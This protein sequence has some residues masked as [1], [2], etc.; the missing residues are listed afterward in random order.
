MSEAIRVMRVFGWEEL[1]GKKQISKSVY[2]NV[3]KVGE[4]YAY[5]KFKSDHLDRSMMRE[6]K[7]LSELV[8]ENI[9]KLEG[10][11]L[12]ES[13]R[14]RGVILPLYP[15]DLHDW[16][17]NNVHYKNVQAQ[18]TS[19]LKNM[20]I[21][22]IRGVEYIHSSGVMHCDIKEKNIMI[23]SSASNDLMLGNNLRLVIID[24]GLA[25]EVASSVAFTPNYKP[26][27]V[28]LGE[29]YNNSADIWSLGCVTMAMLIGEAPFFPNTKKTDSQIKL[30]DSV[31]LLDLNE[32]VIDIGLP[33]KK[34]FDYN[35]ST[36]ITAKQLLF[37]FLRNTSFSTTIT[38]TKENEKE[39]ETKNENE[40]KKGKEKT[41]IT[42]EN[43]LLRNK[44]CDCVMHVVGQQKLRG[45]NLYEISIYCFYIVD[46]FLSDVSDLQIRHIET[47]ID[48]IAAATVSLCLKFLYDIESNPHLEEIEDII[49]CELQF[50]MPTFVSLNEQS[51]KLICYLLFDKT[52]WNY[53][54]YDSQIL[55]LSELPEKEY[56]KLYS[57]STANLEDL[58]TETYTPFFF[59][60]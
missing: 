18:F 2:G 24:F 20:I 42:M 44:I 23:D 43:I 29:T 8:H 10:V 40:N 33:I 38:N 1:V 55:K 6:V 58:I 22:L 13:G 36:R 50:C 56:Q 57:T 41:K 30:I 49:F 52:S 19:N 37:H 16:I 39:K 45:Y 15:I 47:Q 46:L 31:C 21:Q 4:G 27:E 3:Y 9:I 26:I 17:N 7:Y 53:V 14:L 54:N 48:E 51:A 32:Y 59:F 25:N 28:L 5:K 34:I 35:P 12:S 11:Y 60:S